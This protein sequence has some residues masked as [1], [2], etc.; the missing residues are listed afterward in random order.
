MGIG[1]LPSASLG[2]ELGGELSSPSFI[3]LRA[4]GRVRPAESP[5]PPRVV[6][7][8]FAVAYAGLGICP[9]RQDATPVVVEACVG[10]DVGFVHAKSEGLEGPR[11]TTK[12]LWQTTAAFRGLFAINDKWFVTA[13][14]A[15]SVRA[16]TGQFRL[17]AQ[18]RFDRR[19][20]STGGPVARG[21]PR[22][23]EEDSVS[24]QKIPPF[25]TYIG[26]QRFAI[27]RASAQ[28]VIF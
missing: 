21:R 24:D 1:V 22:C 12:R 7:I 4:R 19:D 3:G 20:P 17:S 11:S 9:L 27:P 6:S 2:A 23:G 13:S 28:I 14:I 26:V 8:D 16:R 5:I 25:P 10:A 15:R 18:Q